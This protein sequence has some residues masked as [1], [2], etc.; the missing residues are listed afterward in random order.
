MYYNVVE[1]A[2]FDVGICIITPRMIL[3][4]CVIS[5]IKALLFSI[6]IL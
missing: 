5:Q 6:D 2:V 4:S 3:M 1:G